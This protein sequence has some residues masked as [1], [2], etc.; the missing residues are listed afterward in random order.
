[1]VNH[2][3]VRFHVSVNDSV[4]VAKVESFQKFQEVES[5]IEIAESGIQNL[6]R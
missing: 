2:N 6:E 1:M 5:N 3:I 4:G